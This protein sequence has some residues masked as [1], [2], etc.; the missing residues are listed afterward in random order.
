MDDIQRF[1]ALKRQ[2]EMHWE[3]PEPFDEFQRP[4]F[5]LDALPQLFQA[6]VLAIAEH[7]QMYPDMPALELLAAVSTACAGKVDIE[8]HEGW[9]EPIQT[10]TMVCMGVGERKSP[11]IKLASSPLAAWQAEKARTMAG[12]ISANQSRKRL[13]QN[14]LQKAESKGDEEAADACARELAE[15]KDITAP[16]IMTDDITPEALASVMAANH[17]TAS[18]WSSEGG[19]LSILGGRYANKDAGPNIDLI[20]K[21]YT[22]DMAAVD[23]VGRPTEIISCPALTIMLAVQ[24]DVLEQLMAN[25]AFMNRGLCGRFMYSLPDSKVGHRKIHSSPIPEGLKAEYS[26]IIMYMLDI[27][28]PEEKAVLK[29]NAE[30]LKLFDQWGEEIEP[31]LAGEWKSIGGWANKLHGL[32]LRLAGQVHMACCRSWEI[33]IDARTM[34]AAIKLARYAAAHALAAFGTCAA[35]QDTVK[36]KRVLEL[37]REKR[38][39]DF[40]QHELLRALR[41]TKAK[42]LEQPLIMLEDAG[43]ICKDILERPS[44]AAKGRPAGVRWV[45]NPAVLEGDD[46]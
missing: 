27:P 19:L 2:K 28:Y 4:P 34:K 20:L 6:Y 9:R 32:T 45:V 8:A 43:Y 23:R 46:G 13:L 26:R 10:Y 21:A 25:Q 44:D 7:L 35:D 15:F 16:R 24:P 12:D 1:E 37:I 36:A 5:P 39:I 18:I 29:L 40:S 30:A 14:K 38:L 42:E 3:A 31:K 33:P 11:V 22:S 41:G 17:G